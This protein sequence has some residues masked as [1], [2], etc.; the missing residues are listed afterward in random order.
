ME[1]DTHSV[2]QGMFMATVESILLYERKARTLTTTHGKRLDRSYTLILRS[3][4]NV[5]WS[6]RRTNKLLY[7]SLPSLS[8][9]IRR[10]RL[11]F[12]E[13]CYRRKKNETVS[14]VI[15]WTTKLGRPK[16]CRLALNFIDILKKDTGLETEELH[17][18]QCL[19]ERTG[20]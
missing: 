8:V 20:S 7:G 1:V 3:P 19:I 12:A 2:Y 17:T 14:I 9:K 10:R 13:H 18:Q 11:R 6:K 16:Q 4:F 15:F 5:H